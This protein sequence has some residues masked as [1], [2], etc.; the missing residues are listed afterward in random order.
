MHRCRW[1]LVVI[2]VLMAV[3]ARAQQPEWRHPCPS[4]V[5]TSEE[6]LAHDQ[7]F[8]ARAIDGRSYYRH[9]LQIQLEDSVSVVGLCRILFNAH[10][11]ALTACV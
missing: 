1:I 8:A 2:L 9:V 6:A 10:A 11:I 3:P 5:N 4:A 7:R